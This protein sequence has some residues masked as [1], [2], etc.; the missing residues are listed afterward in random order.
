MKVKRS[1]V[2]LLVVLMIAFFVVLGMI[3]VLGKEKEREASKPQPQAKTVRFPID[4][5]SA[6][7]DEL[8]AIPGIGTVKA[9]AIVSHREKIGRFTSLDQLLDVSGIGRKTLEKMEK[10]VFVS[11]ET[12]VN[13]KVRSKINVNTATQEEL[14]GLPSIGPAKAKAIVEYRTK[15]GP[16]QSPE[17]LLKVPGIGEKTLE[18]LRGEITF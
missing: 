11:G 15:N 6:T 1:E 3:E 4:L 16:F 12:Q 9:Q 2:K 14:E 8:V 7:V 17:D 18:K 13:T 5:N 10:Y